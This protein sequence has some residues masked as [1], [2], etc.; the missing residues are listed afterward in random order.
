MEMEND[1]K[2]K[3]EKVNEDEMEDEKKD[4]VEEEGDENFSDVDD[5]LD[6]KMWEGDED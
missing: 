3:S 1:F 4:K 2:G 5:N 6:F